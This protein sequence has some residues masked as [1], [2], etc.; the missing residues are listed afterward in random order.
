[1]PFYRVHLNSGK[2]D[3]FYAH[4]EDH[5]KAIATRE[6]GPNPGDQGEEVLKVECLKPEEEDVEG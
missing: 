2:S 3:T 5:A 6:H 4:S 1:M